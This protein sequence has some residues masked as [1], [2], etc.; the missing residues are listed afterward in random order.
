MHDAMYDKYVGTEEAPGILTKLY[1]RFRD[2][3]KQNFVGL[4]DKEIYE[5]A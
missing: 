1:F 2:E 4:T 3:N 5:K